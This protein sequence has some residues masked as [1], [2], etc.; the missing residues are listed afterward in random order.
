[1]PLG[2]TTKY[3]N[4]FNSYANWGNY[5]FL[6]QN[7]ASTVYPALVNGL[8]EH[9]WTHKGTIDYVKNVISSTD[10]DEKYLFH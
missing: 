8:T 6:T 5:R 3:V 4:N 1:M 10:R 7:G 9:T 2:L